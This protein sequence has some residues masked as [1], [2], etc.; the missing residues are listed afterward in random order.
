[1]VTLFHEVSQGSFYVGG[2]PVDD[3]VRVIIEHTA[4][5]RRGAL[6]AGTGSPT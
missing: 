2:E 3:V 6:R 1:V 4:Q 5:N